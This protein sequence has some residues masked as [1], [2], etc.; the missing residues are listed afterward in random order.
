MDI[1][2]Y[3]LFAL[4]VVLWLLGDFKLYLL[5]REAPKLIGWYVVVGGAYL[6]FMV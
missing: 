6:L 4:P 3:I 5:I 1:L 2:F